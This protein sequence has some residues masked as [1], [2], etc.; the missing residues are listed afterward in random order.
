MKHIANIMR[1]N[2]WD[3]NQES[4]VGRILE[5]GRG[6]TK[7][8]VIE[9]LGGEKTEVKGGYYD[10]CAIGLNADTWNFICRI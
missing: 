5:Y 4:T 9:W 7:K 8:F 10:A 3:I 2:D 1:M 6:K